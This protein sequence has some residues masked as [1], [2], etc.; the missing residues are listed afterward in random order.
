MGFTG[1]RRAGLD[2]RA[3]LEGARRCVLRRAQARQA[4]PAGVLKPLEPDATAIPNDPVWPGEGQYLFGVG[5]M[6][7]GQLHHRPDLPP[8]LGHHDHRQGRLQAASAPRRSAFTEMILRLGRTPARAAAQATRD[9]ARRSCARRAARRGL[10][11]AAPAAAVTQPPQPKSGPG[12]SDSAPRLARAPP[13]AAGA[14]AWYVFEP[15]TAAPE[16]GAAGDRHARLLRVL[17]LRQMYELIRHTVRKGN[18]VIYPRWQTAVVKPCPGPFDIEPCI[19][20]RSRA[21]AAPEVPARQQAP[22]AAAAAAGRATSA[23]PSAGSSPR[24]S[25]TATRRSVCPEPRAI[26]LED[27]HDGGLAGAGEPAL[28]D[29]LRRHPSRRSSCSATPAPTA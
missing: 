8:Q 18:V 28:D 2:L 10:R 5:E 22:R 26:F 11:L 9:A 24:T 13:A 25:R 4:A 19:S 12:G 27:P 29:S 3:R 20:P 23:S 21:S 14:N 6:P 16:A 17:R 1:P 15:A 7:D